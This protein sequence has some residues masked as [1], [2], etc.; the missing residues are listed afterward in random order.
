MEESAI[1]TSDDIR[2]EAKEL[3]IK[4]RL[5]RMIAVI[6]AVV[7]F[8][9][10]MILYFKN[11]EGNILEALSKPSMVVIIL[12]PFLPAAVLSWLSVRTEERFYRLVYKDTDEAP[13]KKNKK[14]KKK[15]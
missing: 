5:Y 6:F 11:I 12:V 2:Q 8:V 9:V 4:A 13:A 1:S 7:G 14:N 15:K 3:L 10:F